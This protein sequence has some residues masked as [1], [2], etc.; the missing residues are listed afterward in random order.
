M[1][2]KIIAVNYQHRR[3]DLYPLD[4]VIREHAEYLKARVLGD[5]TDLQVGESRFFRLDQ[6]TLL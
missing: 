4:I 2:K 5:N 1:H 3:Y 6:I